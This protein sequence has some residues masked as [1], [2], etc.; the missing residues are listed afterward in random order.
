MILRYLGNG[1][2]VLLLAVATA[3]GSGIVNDPILRL[4]AEEA[5]TEGRA[6]MDAKKYRL[7]RR[8]LIHAFEV[9]PNSVSGREGLLLAADALYFQGGFDSFVEAETRYRDFINRFPTSS[10]AEYAQFQVARCLASRMEKPNRDQ[11]TTRKALAAF[12]ELIRIYPTSA[13]VEEANKEIAAV[14]NK[15]ADHEFI[16]GYFYFRTSG[17]RR[18]RGLTVAAVSR[19]ENLLEDYPNYTERAEVLYYLC[20][21]HNRIEQPEKASQVCGQLRSEFPQSKFLKKLPELELTE[22]AEPKDT[23]AP[24]S[25]TVDSKGSDR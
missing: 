15:L 25:D 13:Y 5:L 19:F 2:P 16:V 14:R 4:S 22:A 23:G 3:C 1:L 11:E 8:Y 9:E 24:A 10:R 12:E 17:A 18:A 6:M 7:A 20:R 21:A